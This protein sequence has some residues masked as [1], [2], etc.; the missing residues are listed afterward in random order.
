MRKKGQYR[1]LKVQL[2][3]E[4]HFAPMVDC[5]QDKCLLSIDKCHWQCD[6]NKGTG[7]KQIWCKWGIVHEE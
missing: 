2:L 3:P 6:Y 7:W 4:N 5:P 1:R